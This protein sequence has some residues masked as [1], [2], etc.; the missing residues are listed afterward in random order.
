M[1]FPVSASLLWQSASD[2]F[3]IV[4]RH[5]L[6]PDA[7]LIRKGYMITLAGLIFILSTV[8]MWEAMN[9][10]VMFFIGAGAFLYTSVSN[11]PEAASE[12]P[13]KFVAGAA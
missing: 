4:R 11:E 10:M 1:V 13:T 5:N 12:R 2:I 8:F 9:V 3:A 6:S 7:Q